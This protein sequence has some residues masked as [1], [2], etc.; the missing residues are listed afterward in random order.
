MIEIN[1]PNDPTNLVFVASPTIRSIYTIARAVK[2]Y[3]ADRVNV[4]D[5]TSIL[6][7]PQQPNLAR[8]KAVDNILSTLGIPVYRKI[9][10]PESVMPTVT[11]GVVEQTR[12]LLRARQ[13]LSGVLNHFRDAPSDDIEFDARTTLA[14]VSLLI[15]YGVCND[16]Y[17]V[18]DA[19]PITL[20]TPN[21][22]NDDTH[23]QFDMG[24]DLSKLWIPLADVS[25]H[26]ILYSAKEEGILPLLNDIHHC[27]HDRPTPCGGCFGC[28]KYK[29]RLLESGV[30]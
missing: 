7:K 15:S 29:H 13:G 30:L 25:L 6:T 12:Y 3:G 26:D 11:S 9:Y 17:I 22:S 24:V 2:R 21:Y 20:V 18:N 28:T 16:Q 14:C 19:C 23:R 5:V 27:I 10:V 4:A 8:Q 1:F